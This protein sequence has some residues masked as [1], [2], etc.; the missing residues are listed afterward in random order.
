MCVFGLHIWCAAADPADPGVFMSKKYLRMR[1]I[2]KHLQSRDTKLGGESTSIQDVK[3][4]TLDGKVL[5][6]HATA[7]EAKGTFTEIEK[8]NASSQNSS[9]FLWALIP[10]YSMC[11]CCG[12]GEDPSEH[13][14]SE[15]GMFYCS[16]CEVE[17]CFLG[18]KDILFGASQSFLLATVTKQI[19]HD[20]F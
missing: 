12:L 19:F 16:L 3:S 9:C 20:E 17:V 8:N 18:A 7:L 5:D 15:D 13:Q 2:C 10:C 4:A 11:N 14:A 1:D 6:V